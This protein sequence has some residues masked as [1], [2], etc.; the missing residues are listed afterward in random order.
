M[1]FKGG[2]AEGKA[3]IAGLSCRLPKSDNIDEFWNNLI[4]GKDMIGETRWPV[5]LYD[6][7]PR[8]GLINGIDKFDAGFFRFTDSEAHNMNP[9][10]RHLFEVSY[11][12]ITDSGIPLSV[13]H[14]NTTGT[15]TACFIPDNDPLET[16]RCADSKYC[17]TVSMITGHLMNQFRFTG[18]SATVDSACSSSVS[19]MEMAVQDLMTGRC[20]FA[21]V[22][23][24]NLLLN[25]SYLQQ[26]S[27]L[28]MLSSEGQSRVF[29]AD[30]KGYV[31][32]E[33][34][35]SILL[36]RQA[37]LCQRIYCSVIDVKTSCNGY[38]PDG[39]TFPSKDC[40]CA[41][42]KEIYKR[43]EVKW[44]DIAYMELHS[45]GTPVGDPIEARSV[46]EAICS[47][48][49]KP[50][51]IGSVKANMGH[52][53]ATAGLASLVKCILAARHGIIPPQINF[54]TPNPNIEAIKEGKIVVVK[55]PTELKGKTFCLIPVTARTVQEQEAI[56]D[57]VSK[58]KDDVTL[59]AHLSLSLLSYDV[60]RQIRGYFISDP[61]SPELTQRFS[62]EEPTCSELW[63]CL[64]DFIWDT[65]DFNPQLLNNGCFMKSIIQSQVIVKDKIG[66]KMIMTEAL[67]LQ[68]KPTTANG[69]VKAIAIMIGI[70]DCLQA[71]KV[72][73]SGVYGIGLSEIV[74]CY[75][76]NSLTREQCL[77]VAYIVGQT[78]EEHSRHSGGYYQQLTDGIIL[79]SRLLDSLTEKIKDKLKVVIQEPKM[80]SGLMKNPKHL[81]HPDQY[82][83][84]GAVSSLLNRVVRANDILQSMP[85]NITLINVNLNGVQAVINE[86]SKSID[87]KPCPVSFL[88]TLGEIHMIGQ[89]IDVSV[90]YQ[91]DFPLDVKSPSISS[92]IRW[93]HSYS[94]SI[95]DWPEFF[96]RV[97]D[98]AVMPYTIDLGDSEGIHTPLA[99]LIYHSWIAISQKTSKDNS[100]ESKTALD[101]GITFSNLDLNQN[102]DTV[103]ELL[104]GAVV[105]VLQGK[106]RFAVHNNGIVLFS[107]NFILSSEKLELPKIPGYDL[108]INENIEYAE[109]GD[110]LQKTEILWEDNWL[111]FI[112][113]V[114]EFNMEY[115]E[116]GLIKVMIDPI[117]VQEEVKECANVLA[118]AEK[119]TGLCKAGS[120][121]VQNAVTFDKPAVTR[122]SNVSEYSMT[123]VNI[124][125]AYSIQSQKSDKIM[126][127]QGIN[128]KTKTGVLGL[129]LMT[130][131]DVICKE[132]P[133]AA[134]DKWRIEDIEQIIPYLI[135]LYLLSESTESVEKPRLLI[136]PPIDTVGM[137]LMALSSEDSG[138]SVFTSSYDI[139]TRQMVESTF[140]FVCVLPGDNLVQSIKAMTQGEGCDVCIKFT[141][142]ELNTCIDFIGTGGKF[143]QCAKPLEPLEL[144][145]LQHNKTFILVDVKKAFFSFLS[146]SQEE[147]Q[148]LLYEMRDGAVGKLKE[149]GYPETKGMLYS[150]DER[151]HFLNPISITQILNVLDEPGINLTDSFKCLM[152]A[153]M[154]A[155]ERLHSVIT[156]KPKDF[157]LWE[158]VQFES[159]NSE[160]DENDDTLN[161]ARLASACESVDLKISQPSKDVV[162][163]R[164]PNVQI[165]LL[166]EPDS[167]TF[168]PP[169]YR[170]TSTPMVTLRVHKKSDDLHE[171]YID[172]PLSDNST[173][174]K[175]DSL[176]VKLLPP[177]PMIVTP[178]P[179]KRRKKS[180]PMDLVFINSP[181]MSPA[182]AFT[183]MTPSIRILLTPAIKEPSLVPLNSSPKQDKPLYIVHPITGKVTLL[184][185]L[186]GLLTRQC[187]GIQRT[188]FTPRDSLYSV[189]S[190]YTNAVQMLQTTGPYIIAGYSFGTM[191]AI[192][193]ALQLQANKKK[194]EKLILFDGGPDYFSAQF[195]A[196]Q[197][198]AKDDSELDLYLEI[199]ALVNF[200]MMFVPVPSIQMLQ[201]ILHQLPNQEARIQ[202]VVEM[203]FKN[204][205]ICMT[206]TKTKWLSA[207]EKLFS[208]KKGAKDVGKSSMADAAQE[209]LSWKRREQASD[210]IKSVN[211]VNKYKNKRGKF[212]GDIHLLRIK[213]D[214]V[215]CEHLP[216]DYGLQSWCTGKVHITFYNG[217]H[218]TFLNRDSGK[219]VAEEITKI[220]SLVK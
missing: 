120:L 19:A 90:F 9:L 104:Q 146:R 192:E 68:V 132:I 161:E 177:N 64:Q 139:E 165:T 60:R 59:M 79:Y 112:N 28:G 185:T 168:C 184:K 106:Q 93:D 108:D 102:T 193:M 39:I 55:E 169:D 160:E 3:V 26:M 207:K 27:F 37:S 145:K 23:A 201:N 174:I 219:E 116:G 18:P 211:M 190:Y 61:N 40:Q 85:P 25:P 65:L 51:L 183:P 115:L 143:L 69:F 121:L 209:V 199:G 22:T 159:Q 12:C 77:R 157:S 164:V 97:K 67:K 195:R 50:L 52:S 166:D 204:V 123:S 1:R 43:S 5:G 8:A 33:G 45:T 84:S 105:Q 117:S 186:G 200:L 38:N 202:T 125:L 48:R 122:K 182:K 141:S 96:S 138:I 109:D 31:R 16:S 155:M 10:L 131:E 113:T 214:P 175:K 78:I 82:V 49:E 21:L 20:Q 134:D 198:A 17:T 149:E 171:S 153:D 35:V 152:E 70:V 74:A 36:T 15:Y 56:K 212:Q 101:R 133:L 53:E 76:D 81:Q 163:V 178:V 54:K 47:A 89:P 114:L 63:L 188:T 34:I 87:C 142:G 24:C 156:T 180:R 88:K 197:K 110:L 58:N 128:N 167:K 91:S 194:V 100:L 80:R 72:N 205:E 187:Y 42:M 13:L 191:V 170:A 41:L 126:V 62:D 216:V 30:A 86:E 129:V 75:V 196:A 73:I 127:Y 148:T 215:M 220:L 218:E 154:L 181:G 71:A 119:Y 92:L 151:S 111:D 206:A 103:N 44:D 14:S 213:S 144:E 99:T 118:V 130:E 137:Y 7:P 217:S 173:C 32:A 6:T 208:K 150:L 4:N 158:R 189:A 172:I 94:W 98:E 83:D 136:C 11:E 95:P 210:F 124:V 107:G 46:T 203:S 176:V 57:F 140:P 66:L 162:I 2:R 29:D 135:A 147:I 179:E